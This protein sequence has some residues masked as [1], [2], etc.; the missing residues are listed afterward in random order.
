MSGGGVMAGRRFEHAEPADPREPDFLI[1]AI[2]RREPATLER[3]ARDNLG[4]SSGW[5]ARPVVPS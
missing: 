5:R 4:P 1:A 2:Q 3:V